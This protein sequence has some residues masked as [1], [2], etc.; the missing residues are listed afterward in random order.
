MSLTDSSSPIVTLKPR[1]AQPFFNRHPWVFTGAISRVSGQ[2]VAGSEVVVKTFEGKFVARGLFN[3]DSNIRVRL[4]TW[5][6]QQPIDS[7]F[8]AQQLDA[9][10]ALRRA[11]FTSPLTTAYRLVFSESD[12]LSGL[13]VDKYDDWLLVQITSRALAERREVLFD[14]L[15]DRLQPKGIWLRTEKGIGESE[16]LQLNDGL[17]RG[18]EPPRPLRVLENGLAVMVDVAEGQKTGAFLDQR[19]NRVAAARFCKDARVLDLF[20]YAGGFGIHAAG[21]G[22]C[23]VIC[24]DSSQSALDSALTNAT[25]NQVADRIQCVRSDVFRYLEQARAAGEVFDVVVLDPPKMA[26]RQAGLDQA[27]RGYHSLN[28]MSASL[29]RPGGILVTC[30]CSGRVS[31]ADFEMM[32]AN[33]STSLRRPIQILESR[34]QPADHPVSPNCPENSYLKCYICR[35]V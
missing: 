7:A 34:G 28:A 22:A 32:L 6:E 15:Q 26:R 3:P 11:F 30:S 17:V 21:A 1:A 19:D 33:V 5:D 8:L 14:L 31:R 35:V 16:G 23:S 4:Y 13:T 25:E 20:C 10:L 2:P 9:A 24:V 18:V 12:G 27:L 29:V